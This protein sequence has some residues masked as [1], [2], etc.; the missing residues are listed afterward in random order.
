ML[1]S[2]DWKEYALIDSGDGRRLERLGRYTVDRPDAEAIWRPGLPEA[3][4]RKAQARFQP[5]A[6]ENGGHWERSAK[7]P[8][9]WQMTYKALRFRVELGA[10]RHIGFFPEQA[11]QWDW[12]MKKIQQ[13][14]APPRVLNLFGYTGLASLAC[15]VAGAQVTHVDASRKS[16]AWAKENQTLSGLSD[17]PIRWLV[18]DALKFVQREQRRGSTY[19]GI[20]LDPP[21]FGRGPKGEVWD[22]YR[23]IQEL[24]TS[25]AQL[26]SDQALF[27]F[28]TAYAVKASALTLKTALE[29]LPFPAGGVFEAG[30]F[31][32][33]ENERG[34]C[35]PTAVF[36]RWS[37]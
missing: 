26:L 36:A 33:I 7:V 13:R 23:Y 20:L 15:A 2:S 28:V 17:K 9:S 16:V 24:L 31:V 1:I 35:L 32:L 21:K 25:C 11:V 8:E 22:F 14:A 18:D 37:R 4:W 6:E 30:E 10:S 12:M 34:R 29:N 19:E 3:N 27:C 5:T